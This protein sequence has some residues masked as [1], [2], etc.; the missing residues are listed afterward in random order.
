M[1]FPLLYSARGRGSGAASLNTRQ[2]S[3]S[4]RQN[5]FKL[6]SLFSLFSLFFFFFFFFFFLT[7]AVDLQR[8]HHSGSKNPFRIRFAF[9]GYPFGNFRPKFLSRKKGEK[10][11]KK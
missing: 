4:K 3:G 5:T 11:E 7:R 2:R 6:F 8:T 10:E 9:L 1:F